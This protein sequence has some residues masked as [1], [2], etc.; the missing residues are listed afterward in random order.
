MQDGN[1]MKM[2]YDNHLTTTMTLSSANPEHIRYLA[3]FFQQEN[4]SFTISNQTN[5]M[6]AN[7]IFEIIHSPIR[8]YLRIHQPSIDLVRGPV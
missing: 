2:Y 4:I 8:E 1:I 3:L 6:I 5:I 7:Q